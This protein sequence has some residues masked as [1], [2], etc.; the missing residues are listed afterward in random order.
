MKRHELDLFSLVTGAAFV[1]VAVLYLLD[2]A[3]V[4]SVQ[5]RLVI[6]LLLIGLGVGGLAG[7]LY[8]MAREGRAEQEREPEPEDF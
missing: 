5:A 3:G 6:P 2:S 7:A 1:T 4:L 8:R